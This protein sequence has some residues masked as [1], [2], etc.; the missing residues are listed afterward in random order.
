MNDSTDATIQARVKQLL[1]GEMMMLF[2]TAA[3]PSERTNLINDPKHS[4]EIA[5][6][7]QKLI[8]HM[9]QTG[10]PELPAFEAALTKHLQETR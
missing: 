2:D 10:D 7:S 4:N 6:L 5:E 9:K 8:A 1:E 3:D